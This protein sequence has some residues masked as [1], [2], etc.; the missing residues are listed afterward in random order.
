VQIIIDA[1][2][3][4]TVKTAN[5][6]IGNLIQQTVTNPIQLVDGLG[7]DSS[8][9]TVAMNFPSLNTAVVSSNTVRVIPR[10]SATTLTFSELTIHS[11]VNPIARYHT[12][13]R[14]AYRI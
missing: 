13:E 9:S 8:P 11:T 2:A 3:E 4:G 10:Q 7:N 1:E 5:G 12:N 6:N 14:N